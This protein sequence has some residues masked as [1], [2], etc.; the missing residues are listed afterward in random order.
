MRH[1]KQSFLEKCLSAL[2]DFANSKAAIPVLVGAL[3]ITCI[4]AGVIALNGNGI[5]V[6]DDE[7]DLPAESISYE[8][9]ADDDDYDTASA[10][11]DATQYTGTVLEETE[12][13]G[14]DYIDNTLFLGDSNTVRF[15]DYGLTTLENT[16][17]VIGMGAGAITT[18][19]CA[20]FEGYSSE[21]TMLEAVEIMQPQRIVFSFGTN[22]LTGSLSGFIESYEEAIQDTYDNYPYFDV[23]VNAIPPVDKNR[24]YTNISMQDIDEFN[25]AL[26]DMCE[27]ND[28][29][30]L[31]SS[32]AL[33]DSNT[34]FA[35]TSYTLSDGLHLSKDGVEA[36]F[37]YIAT[38]AYETE[39]IRPKPL[40]AVPERGE[41]PPDLIVK[42]PIKDPDAN[43]IIP[44]SFV[45]SGGGYI[46]GSTEQGVRKGVST[47]TV[48]AYPND[49]YVFAGW[50]CSYA[51]ISN[52]AEQSITYT[53]PSDTTA[54]GGIVVTAVFEPAA[55]PAPS[56]S[57]GVKTLAADG[58]TLSEIGAVFAASTFA[59]GTTT[60]VL[61]INAGYTFVGVDN[62]AVATAN[63]DGTYSVTTTATSGGIT[64][65]V[66]STQAVEPSPSASPTPDATTAPPTTEPTVE[67]TTPPATQDPTPTAEPV[68]T[69]TA[70]PVA[71]PTAEPVATEAPPESTAP[72]E[73]SDAATTA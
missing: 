4:S 24:A 15:M 61:T 65:T 64:A 55:T 10:S 48:T 18:L 62:G 73:S 39:D 16:V 42:D 67:P 60:A 59:D 50:Q 43:T 57:F 31:N 53:P 54:F 28:W 9:V 45:V 51:G 13:A 12:D 35:Q 68:A 19:D 2:T 52:N 29:K 27:E 8:N 1:Q 32:E 40:T 49:G 14:K 69:P 22:N 20:V 46:E 23:I 71:T 56:V 11:I 5:S 38:H 7:D 34:G 3:A 44:V 21:V 33:K 70:E 66:K 30:F 36:L 25:T 41:T 58:S 6:K 37:D 26:V 63:G 17:A 47:S 72:P